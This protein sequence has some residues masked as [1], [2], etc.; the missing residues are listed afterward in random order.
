MKKISIIV[1][2]YNSEKYLEKCLD[3][4]INQTFKDLEIILINDG[5]T[6]N[7]QEII[8]RYKIKDNRII[9]IKKTNSGQGE[10]RNVGIKNSHGKFIMFVDSDDYVDLNIC[11]KLYDVAELNNAD[12]V[13]TDY[14]EVDER[15]NIINNQKIKNVSL[16]DAKKLFLTTQFGP[17][18]KL[19]KSEIIKEN[20]LLFPSFRAYEDIG[21]VPAW[22]LNSKKIYYLSESL[23]YYL[24]RKGSTMNQ[25]KY[26]EK[27]TH[28]FASLNNLKQYFIKNKKYDE[29]LEWIYIE[30]LLHAASLRFFKFD[31]YLDNINRIV[32]IIKE[33]Y[34]H[35][36][37]NK[38]YKNQSI[39][40]KVVCNLIYN[41]N[42]KLL[43]LILKE[44]V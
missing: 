31:N 42:F 5:S 6:D 44:S 24:I 3:S 18:A 32:K 43:R 2:V 14:Y 30:H 41:K 13:F 7:S 19:I 22:G 29:E 8:N 33:E 35:W 26:N 23:Y 34:P 4:L 10:A 16:L 39:K 38:Y 1:P 11:K 15:D 25:T 21:V 12:L 17:C 37:K 28:I 40:Y 9:C 36:R 20:K 27:L